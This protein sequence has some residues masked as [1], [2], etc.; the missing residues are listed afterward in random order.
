MQNNQRHFVIAGV[1]VV[2]STFLVYWLL[3]AVLKLPIQGSGQAFEIDQ[4][5]DYHIW[6]IAFLFS[7]ITVF[8]LYALVVF[9]HRADEDEEKEGEYFHG[10]VRLEIAWTLIPLIFVVFFSFESTRVLINITR[11]DP[12]EYVINVEGYQWGWNFTYP[13]TG[14]V[15]QELVLP[16]NQPI[17][18]DMTS[19]DVL[20]NFWVPEFR[21]KQDL[22][23]G[24]EP[25]VLRF[26]PVETGE[27]TVV[28]AELCGLNHTGMHAIVRVVPQDEFAAWMNQQVASR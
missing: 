11:A 27:Y 24:F 3:D 7:L 16:A 12:N 23:P 25:R 22:L 21:V 6:L 17:R 15:T 26:T 1:L 19:R 4:L 2:V 13:E 18:L 14:L 28:C 10:N 20:H 5:F 9:R 8:M